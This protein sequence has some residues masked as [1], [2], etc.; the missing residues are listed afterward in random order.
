MDGDLHRILLVDDDEPTNTLHKLIIEE[1]G[2]GAD[3]H[4]ATTGMEAL[5]FLENVEADDIPDLIFL[6]LNMPGMSG[7]EFMEVY[8]KLPPEKHAK[9]VIVMLTT[10]LAQ[11]DSKR[12]LDLGVI[13]M[14]SKPLSPDLLQE[15]TRENF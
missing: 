5:A 6:D 12:L 15:I 7:Y 11:K 8:Q 10:S 3:I 4:I 13:G 1:S 14:K 2:M 9:A